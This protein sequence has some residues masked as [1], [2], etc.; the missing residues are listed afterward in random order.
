MD[1]SVNENTDSKVVEKKPGDK[2]K[3]SGFV[4]FLYSGG[5]LVLIVLGFVLM[6]V[7]FVLT[8]KK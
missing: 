4:K 3:E 7:Y 2:K 6:I 1:A 8:G 5:I